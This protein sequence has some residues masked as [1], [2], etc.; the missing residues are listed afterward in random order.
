MIYCE[1]KNC[2]IQDK[3]AYHEDFDWKYPRQYL[4]WSTHGSGCEGMDDNGNRFSHHEFYCGDNASYYKCYKALGYREG[5]KYKNSLGFCYDQECVDCKFRSLCFTLL[6]DAG[7][8][9]RNG[10]RVMN[11]ICKDIKKDPQFYINKLEQKWGRKFE[12]LIRR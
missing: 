6:E 11:H 4:D 10:E 5:E 8:I 12:G 7:L 9:T 2:S 3:C 1:G